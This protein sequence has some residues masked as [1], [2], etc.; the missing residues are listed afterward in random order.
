MLCRSLILTI[1]IAI[2]A[3][4]FGRAEEAAEI[5]PSTAC[6]RFALLTEK[7][8]GIDVSKYQGA[9]RWPE[10]K[11]AKVHFVF[12]RVSDG[13]DAPDERFEDNWA[14]AKA[15]GL[16]RG[17]YQYFRPSA[18]PLAQARLYVSAVRRLRKGD[19]PPVLDVETLEGLA[20]KDV[21][22]AIRGWMAFVTK[23]LGRT[24]IL[25]TN[26]STWKALGAPELGVS[27]LW[28]AQW[29]VDCPTLPAGFAQWHFWQ[30]SSDGR[31]AGIDGAVDLDWFFGSL[32]EL[33]QLAGEKPTRR[34]TK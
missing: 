27:M 26:A 31:V 22:A 5:A 17:A 33:R 13:V 14:G 8:A 24:P 12:V 21:V 30:H 4:A 3:P 7:V 28:L 10:V 6:S 15:A 23:Q 11:K 32:D 34:P 18:D 20:A 1:A 2:L 29:G 25:Y 9:V 16:Y 19:L